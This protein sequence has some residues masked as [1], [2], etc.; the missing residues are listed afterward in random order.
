MNI[1]LSL[2]NRHQQHPVAVVIRT[3]GPHYA[4]LKCSKCN[5]W[6]KWLSR[7]EA[8]QIREMTQ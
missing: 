4:H 5:T 2:F 3:R 8:E 1:K 6:L 7:T